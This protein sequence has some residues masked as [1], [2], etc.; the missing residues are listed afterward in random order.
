MASKF[1]NM[2]F[3][4][5]A[6]LTTS[7]SSVTISTDIERSAAV[8][9]TDA[10]NI[11]FVSADWWTIERMTCTAATGTLTIVT[12]WLD[13]STSPSEVS[14]LKKERKT[15]TLIKVV[16]AASDIVDIDADN[17]FTWDNT[18]SWDV[19][20][21]WASTSVD[22]NAAIE[23]LRV[24]NLTTAQLD[25][26]KANNGIIAYDTDLW[27]YYGTNS[28]AVNPFASWSTQANTSTT[29]AGKS[30]TSTSTESSDA[31]S[32]I[33]WTWANI[34]VLPSDIAANTQ[35]WTFVYKADTAS[36]DDYLV[37][38]TPTLT[39][40]TKWQ[41]I[42]F[43]AQTANTW[44]C[45]LN[46]DSKWAKSIKMIDGSDPLDD[47]I[48]VNDIVHVKYNGTN[49]ILMNP[50]RRA[51][52]AQALAHTNTLTYITPAQ[53]RTALWWDNYDVVYDLYHFDTIAGSPLWMNNA[54][55]MTTESGSAWFS[56][57]TSSSTWA[58][59][60]WKIMW[61]E[62]STNDV[63]NFSDLDIIELE[64]RAKLE[65]N[66]GWEEITFWFSETTTAY[67]T[68]ASTD[69]H[70]VVEHTASDAFVLI[71]SAD[72]STSSNSAQFSVTSTNYNTYRLVY[73]VTWGSVELFINWTSVWIKTTNL[74]TGSETCIIWTWTNENAK[75][76]S[77]DRMRVK[78]KRA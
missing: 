70:V 26:L 63:L 33:W 69:R 52:A 73:D 42:Y 41:S 31:D 43:E 28:W 65:N 39:A 72:N 27:D 53:V 60:T 24:P 12:R 5:T 48:A 47:D 1:S 35:S 66:W 14:G 61:P 49:M 36:D 16:H 19:I 21:S 54:A 74:P 25:T 37:A 29:I 7:G 2:A 11:L 78:I 10:A 30:E 9:L 50:A 51:T 18:F 15:G 34:F 58:Y 45:T 22:M 59:I 44:A 68:D 8:T 23:G 3:Y 38:L 62:W 76:I 13:Q 46:I 77:Y 4:S 32:D 40:Y 56:K 17:T 55:N 67:Y 71:R 20:I 64:I 6:K 75:S 57:A